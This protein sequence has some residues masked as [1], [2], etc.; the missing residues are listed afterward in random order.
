LRFPIAQSPL[1]HAAAMKF[2]TRVARMTKILDI[3]IDCLREDRLVKI[4]KPL[5]GDENEFEKLSV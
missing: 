2:G 5:L 1:T 3:F 4:Y